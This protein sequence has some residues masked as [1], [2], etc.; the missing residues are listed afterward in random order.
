[1]FSSRF[2]N[3]ANIARSLCSFWDL[4]SMD[5]GMYQKTLYN[6]YQVQFPVLPF[7]CFE[8]CNWLFECDRRQ[9]RKH[10]KVGKRYTIQHCTSAQAHLKFLLWYAFCLSLGDFCICSL[11]FLTLVIYSRKL[12]IYAGYIRTVSYKISA[13]ML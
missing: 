8:T 6:D 2:N 12:H 13:S 3:A 5:V 7:L 11:Q 4:H 10:W 9:K 1:M